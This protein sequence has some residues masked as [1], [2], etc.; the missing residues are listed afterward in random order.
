MNHKPPVGVGLVPALVSASWCRIITWL[1]PPVF[2]DEERT[3]VASL[4][5]TISLTVLASAAVYIIATPFVNPNPALSW[6]ITGA[7]V[8]PILGGL[9]LMRRGRVQLA[10]GLLSL[11][12]WSGVT[13]LAV[14]AGGVS[15]TG[16]GGGYIAVILV[17][18]LLLGGRAGIGLAALSALTGTVILTAQVQ[19]LLPPPLIPSTSA[20]IWMLTLAY[21]AIVALLLH[22]AKDSINRTLERARRNEHAL[23]Q[24][25][26]ELEAEIGERRRAE[27]ALRESEE[28]LRRA[29]RIAHTGSWTLDLRTNEFSISEEMGRIFQYE[30]LHRG[31]VPLD[32]FVKRIHPLDREHVSSAF[33][34]VIA[35]GAPYDLEFRVI[36]ADGELRILHSQGEII[37]DETGRPVKM[38]GIGLDVTERRQAD[39][40]LSRRA[41]ELATLNAV[42][43]RV[44][45][46]LSLKEVAQAALDEIVPL[47]GPDLAMLFLHKD[48][49]LSLQ[50]K[51]LQDTTLFHDN[52]AVHVVGE[53]LSGLAVDEGKPIYRPDVH[54]EARC[55]WEEDERAEVFSFA[56][57]PLRSGETV[58]GAL[59][60]ASATERDFREDAAFLETLADQVAIGVQ[61]ALLHQEVERRWREL[62]TLYGASLILSQS[63]DPEVIGQTLIEL[64]EQHL[65]YEHGTVAVVDEET[66]GP[67]PL[68]VSAQGQGQDF[69]AQ[70]KEQ[71]RSLKLSQGQ[72]IVG[73]VIEHGEPVRLGDVAQDLRYYALVEEVRSELCVPL[74]LGEHVIGALN[75][76]SAR[77]DAYD[78]QDEWL[79]TALAGPAA[80]AIENARLYEQVRDHAATLEWHVAERTAELESRVA[81]V[82]RLNRAMTN[83]LQDLQA[84]NRKLEEVSQELRRT[85]A[86][87]ETFAYSVSH[88]LKAPLRGIDGYSR[89]LLKEHADRLDDDGRTFVRTICRAA[90][91][92]NQLIDDLLAYSRLERRTVH[93]TQVALLPL[94]EAVIAEFGAE[95][96]AQGVELRVDLPCETV[97]AEAKGLSQALR[98]L[99]SNALKFSHSAAQPRVEIGGQVTGEVCT[100]SVRDN[101]IGFDMQYHDRIFEIFQRLHRAEDFPGT[102]VGLAIVRKAA[103]RM[104]GRVWAESAPGEGATFFLEIPR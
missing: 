31:S 15:P 66:L 88:D 4:L 76:E 52:A 89:L 38:A 40:A 85:N 23:A 30:A 36:R 50:A 45:A 26:R 83:L 3:R 6:L 27:A 44:G 57:L 56:A 84:S 43:R 17:G 59:G 1:A 79:L 21:I 102:G 77:P 104:G 62:S 49:R 68:A 35:S 5:N 60:L 7:M 80:V 37:Y 16:G 33:N 61:N 53:R 14:F 71:L 32:E 48:E 72:G 98:N 54:N 97:T 10:S 51:S 9:F 91:E 73:W 94:V 42:G 82:E 69:V 18:G 46:S 100:I 34:E 64:M 87:L 20:S 11:T 19:G 29:Q 63:L 93:T 95:I 70:A 86:E 8:A 75:V 92:M 24:S 2:E 22:L 78:E 12:L 13:L 81:E 103:R 101:G 28:S 65:A 39:E 90:T 25:N 74:K 58:I 47:V 55:E 96:Q 99:L 67:T 41:R